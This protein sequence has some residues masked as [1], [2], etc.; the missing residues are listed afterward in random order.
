MININTDIIYNFLYIKIKLKPNIY[1][2][3]IYIYKSRK[4]IE[5]KNKLKLLFNLRQIK[6]AQ[7]DYYGYTH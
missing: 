6:T 1:R 7:V 2:K 3:N 4:K 5:D